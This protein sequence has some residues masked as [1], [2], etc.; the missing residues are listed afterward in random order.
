MEEE[1]YRE[2]AAAERDHWWFAARRNIIAKILDSLHLDP[3]SEILEVGCGTGGVL[4]LLS[5]YGNVSALESDAGARAIASARKT[6]R[7]EAGMLPHDIPFGTQ[8]FDVIAMFDVLE[9]IDDDA[10]ALQ[11]LHERLKPQGVLLLTVPAYMFLWGRHDV[12]SQHK[13][14]YVRKRLTELVQRSGY[15]VTYSTYFNTLLFPVVVAVR[16]L[17]RLLHRAEGSDIAMPPHLVN[18]LLRS[19]FSSERFVLPHVR[20]PFGVSLFVV[21]RKPSSDSAVA[22]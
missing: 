3:H 21:A 20:L 4:D 11:A 7:V 6:A 2:L 10:G 18:A 12:V 5:R 13:R 14:R 22:P 19:T 1:V 8:R 15:R 17:N 9:H 16:M